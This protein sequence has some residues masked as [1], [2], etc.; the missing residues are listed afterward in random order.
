MLVSLLAGACT[1]T[2]TPNPTP[3]PNPDPKPTP[4]TEKSYNKKIDDYLSEYYLWNDEYNSMQ[5]DL[6]LNYKDNYDNFLRTTLMSMKTNNLDRKRQ[7]DGSYNIYSNIV[8]TDKSATRATDGVINHT[9]VSKDP[10]SGYGFFN[11]AVAPFQQVNPGDPIHY[12]FIVEFVYPDSPAAKA[13]FKRGTVFAKI[14]GN[15]I[16]PNNYESLYQEIMNPTNGQK[17]DFLENAASANPV[18]LTADQYYPNPVCYSDI[19]TDGTNKIGYLVYTGFDAAYDNELVEVIQHFRDENITDLIL[20]LRYNGG[21]HIMTANMLA[22]CIAGETA[23][24]KVFLYYRYNSDRMAAPSKTTM[25]TGLP[26]DQQTG[27]FAE[28]FYYGVNYD[29]A[30]LNNYTLALPEKRLYVLVTEQTASASEAVINSLRGIGIHVM[31]IGEQTNGKNV[32]MEVED[33]DDGNYSYELSPITFQSYNA[34]ADG[35]DMQGTVPSDGM[36]VDYP[37]D[38]WNYDLVDFGP[39]DPL[40]AT[41]LHLIDPANYAEPVPLSTRAAGA[42]GIGKPLAMPTDS[43]RQGGMIVLPRQHADDVRQT[44][45]AE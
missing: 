40:V 25:E 30:D 26:Y 17:I 11:F 14:K 38:E 29:G 9:Q 41:A 19:F 20:D 35:S 10:E 12:A 24:D 23:N 32:G 1:K 33:F 16:T 36:P 7:T 8:R 18:T 2:D 34:T 4:S 13:G 5:R 21:G 42:T 31:L 3:N 44:P 39:Q 43:H 27:F 28:K 15:Y 37:I 6:T 45:E 22:T